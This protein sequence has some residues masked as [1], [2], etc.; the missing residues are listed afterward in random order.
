VQDTHDVATRQQIA[1]ARQTYRAACSKVQPYAVCECVGSGLAQ[2]VAPVDLIAAARTVRSRTSSWAQPV[3]APAALNGA[4][5]E[6]LERQLAAE[7]S[8]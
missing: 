1:L 2:S 5:V 8:R 6:Q 4:S 3:V 7:C